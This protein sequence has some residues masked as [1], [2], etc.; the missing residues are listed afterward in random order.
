MVLGGERMVFRSDESLFGIPGCPPQLGL[1]GA[2]GMIGLLA[3]M[4][5]VE[6]SIDILEPWNAPEPLRQLDAIDAWSWVKGK[7]WVSDAVAD[8]VRISVEALL[9]VEPS[10]ISPYYLLWY[11]A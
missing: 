2:L 9:S 8:L 4:T 6:W 3:E 1:V 5:L 10:E 11:T 7:W